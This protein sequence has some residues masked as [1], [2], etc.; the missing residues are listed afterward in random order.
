MFTRVVGRKITVRRAARRMFVVPALALVLGV[1]NIASASA[2]LLCA[3]CELGTGSGATYHFWSS[4]GGRV[5]PLTF[6]WN[7]GTNEF[8]VFRMATEQRRF[9]G[10]V[11]SDRNVTEPYWGL[12][13]SHRWWL[14]RRP[15]WRLFVGLGGSYQTA[16]NELSSTHV[17]FASSLGVRMALPYP[18][19]TLELSMRHWSNAGIRLPNHGQDFAMLGVTWAPGASWASR[20]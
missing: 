3:G 7:E 8:G 12:S 20:R 11:A 6:L 17:N 16:E 19:T 13:L 4:T 5:I 14:V 18:G 15:S 9:N 2:S 1:P 10:R